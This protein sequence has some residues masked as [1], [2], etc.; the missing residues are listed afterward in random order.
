MNFFSAFKTPSRP[1]AQWFPVGLASSFPDVGADEESEAVTTLSHPRPACN[2]EAKPGCKAFRIPKT[3]PSEGS[4]VP[5]T[6]EDVPADLT[7]QVLVFQRKGKFH[8]VDHVS[9]CDIHF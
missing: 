7:D 8:A 1:E 2:G 4:E 9:H 3:N 5:V 6:E